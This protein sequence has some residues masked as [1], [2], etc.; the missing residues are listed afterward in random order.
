[1]QHLQVVTL[2]VVEAIRVDCW[3]QVKV[4][5]NH[6]FSSPCV[7]CVV[8]AQPFRESKQQL[9]AVACQAEDLSPNWANIYSHSNCVVP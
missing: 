1:M 8:L 3:H 4:H 2:P 9:P 5:T 6:N 7:G